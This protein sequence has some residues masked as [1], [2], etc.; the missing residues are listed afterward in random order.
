[1]MKSLNLIVLQ[2][3]KCGACE[4]LNKQAWVAKEG[5]LKNIIAPCILG[6]YT[7]P[8]HRNKGYA[9]K[10]INLL[11]K[12]WD[13]KLNDDCFMYLYSEVGDFYERVEYKGFKIPTHKIKLDDKIELNNLGSD[14]EYLYYNSYQDLID[15]YNQRVQNLIVS[16]SKTT[17]KFIYSQIPLI[18]Y[19]S[20]FHLRD[21]HTG[22]ILGRYPTAT[23]IDQVKFGV[24]FDNENY[25]I[26]KHEW[27][28]EELIILGCNTTNLKNLIEL[29]ELSIIEYK[30]SKLKYVYLWDSSI[31]ISI[32]QD[33][34]KHLNDKYPNS[35]F[36]Q[37]NSSI[38]SIRP[39][40]ID[41]RNDVDYIWETNEK[42]GWS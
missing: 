17:S 8:E 2:M 41:T 9:G 4:T 25:I 14:Y 26:W 40:N 11:N 30:Q 27:N 29:F 7:L 16:K 38:P 37:I 28:F 12:Y 39:L 3:R 13:S 18:D 31:P 15:Q 20:W 5:E 42:W 6:V 19:F 23:T 34:L 1:M 35:K 10:M 36:N 22:E 33:F 21:F 32:K 24:K